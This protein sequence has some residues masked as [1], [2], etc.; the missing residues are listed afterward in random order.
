MAAVSEYQAKLEID[1]A[2][3][4]RITRNAGTSITWTLSYLIW[5]A[6]IRFTQ[7]AQEATRLNC[8]HEVEHWAIGTRAERSHDLA[9]ES[10]PR[11]NLDDARI[12]KQ[13]AE[14]C[15]TNLACIVSGNRVVRIAEGWMVEDI[16]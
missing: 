12:R 16:K 4:T 7:M 11:G 13:S 10:K 8:L 15:R 14:S 3:S 2:G 9:L 5:V 6:Q 1:T